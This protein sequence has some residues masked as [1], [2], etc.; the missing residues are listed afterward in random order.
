VADRHFE[1]PRLAAV[2]DALNGDRSDLELYES[3][4]AELGGRRVLDV[5]CG[6]GTFALR[7]A[8]R[9]IEVTGVDPARA[10]LDVA[11]A[12]PGAHRVRWLLGDATCLPP[13]Q[14]D[15]ATMTANVAQAVVEESEWANT[16]Q[17]IHRA[18]RPGGHLVFETRDAS[19]RVW[20]T[21]NQQASRRTTDVPDVGPV[22]T[23][24][25]VTDIA[26]PLVTF[27]STFVFSADGAVLT[28]DSTLRFR[29]Q[30]EVRADLAAQGFVVEGI[31]RALE[32]SEGELVFLARRSV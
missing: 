26:G 25:D 15:V 6:T 30:A 7:L 4:I 28:S 21:W 24:V 12:K 10:S 2:Y 14:V 31:R 17:G 23:W 11:R 1:L 8:D 5:G 9:G 19:R 20:Q 22:D 27:R 3:I 29:T 13:L 32:G 18:L 16:L